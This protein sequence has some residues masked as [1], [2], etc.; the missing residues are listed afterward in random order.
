VVDELTD[1][2]ETAAPSRQRGSSVTTMLDIAKLARVSKSTVSRVLNDAPSRVP[3]AADTR[4]RVLAAASSLGYRPNPLARSLRGAPTMLIGAVVRDFSDPFFASAIEALAVEAMNR[5]YNIILGH[6]HGRSDEGLS[7]TAVLEPRHCDA[8]VILGDI[9]DQ[10]RLLE[11]LRNSALPVVAL[12]QGRSPIEFPTVDIDDRAGVMAGLEH[13]IALGHERIAFVSAALP[14]DNPHREDAFVDF[15][16][17]RFGP[18]PPGYVQR[19]PNTLAGGE[20]ALRK[21]LE[22]PEPPTAIATSTDLVAVGVLHAVSVLGKRVPDD[23]SVVGFD[24]L[25]QA[26]Y[27]VPAL[28]TMRMPVVEIVGEGVRQAIELARDPSLS[29]EPK[30]TMFEPTLVV[31]DSTAS[32]VSRAGR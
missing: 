29:R 5:G 16:T 11:D 31:R 28:T 27:T 12:W 20:A 9:E 4:E 15:M 8:I 32:L 10:P 3:I 24:D 7:L 13:L 25:V 6:V 22:L 30:V 23:F 1:K 19:V 21:L 2:A 18:P 17:V 26:A 14:G